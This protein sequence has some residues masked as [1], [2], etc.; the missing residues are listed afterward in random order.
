MEQEGSMA[1]ALARVQAETA[2]G[3]GIDAAVEQ[4]IREV[5]R[6]LVEKTEGV[7]PLPAALTRTIRDGDAAYAV[8]GSLFHEH[9][10]ASP[11]VLVVV[12]R[13]PAEPLPADDI[14]A[15]LGLTRKQAIVARL[16][17]LRLTNTEISRSLSI[18]E[19]TARHHTEAIMA[20]LRCRS[21]AEVAEL[22]L[23]LET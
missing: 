2:V 12:E 10:G 8:R 22:V 11:A 9:G 7:R 3:T 16:L 18:S 15:S 21:R 13:T 5:A 4:A 23:A 6:A 1:G 14:R 19:H 17:A 20:R